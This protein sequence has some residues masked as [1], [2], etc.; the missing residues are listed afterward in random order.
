MRSEVVARDF[1]LAEVR[2][3]K[4]TE[5]VAEEDAVAEFR[6]ARS[7]P[8]KSG[9]SSSPWTGVA[10]SDDGSTLNRSG[11]AVCP[12]LG[13]EQGPRLARGQATPTC[14]GVY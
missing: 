5:V 7:I 9:N 6:A 14:G 13:A 12:G 4:V 8:M 11:E 1:F 3:G 2:R 10:F